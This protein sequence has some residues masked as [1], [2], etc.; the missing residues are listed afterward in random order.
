MTK[1]YSKI[2][3]NPNLKMFDEFFITPTDFTKSFSRRGGFKGTAVHTMYVIERLTERFG[4]FGKGWGLECK[5]TKI[6]QL[7]NGEAMI[8]ALAGIWYK[9]GDV[10]YVAGH[11]WGG[12]YIAS[13]DKDG[14]L[15]A[16]D[17]AL[18]KAMT[19]GMLKCAAWLGI[20][21]DI[22][23]GLHDDQKY[24]NFINKEEEGRRAGQKGEKK[25]PAPPPEKDQAPPP[26]GGKATPKQPSIRAM[27][28]EIIRLLTVLGEPED[29]ADRKA[30]AFMDAGVAQLDAAG[31]TDPD[32]R[33]A[34]GLGMLQ[35]V[36]D[37]L[38]KQIQEREGG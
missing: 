15:R 16:D 3:E 33:K 28:T 27:R 11:Q 32:E 37:S 34:Q 2:N 24:L 25:D 8:Y 36:I 17:E 13:L 18:K 19:D 21:A 20:G 26:E 4:P 6:V 35:V 7:T 1:R 12:D 5:E 23:Y 30:Q 22:H 9:E 10:V 31:I 14:K 29:E 38:G